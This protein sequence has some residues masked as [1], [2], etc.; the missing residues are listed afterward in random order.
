MKGLS[1]LHGQ[2]FL[3]KVLN[4]AHLVLESEKSWSLNLNKNIKGNIKKEI[5]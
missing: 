1:S 5:D 4:V 2:I 3:Y